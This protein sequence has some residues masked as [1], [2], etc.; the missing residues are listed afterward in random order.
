LIIALSM[1][2][3]DELNSRREDNLLAAIR[4]F[5]GDPNCAAAA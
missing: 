3:F 5:N 1:G 2:L 4:R